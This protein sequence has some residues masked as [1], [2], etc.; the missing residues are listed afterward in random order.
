M[1]VI[2]Q[3]TGLVVMI[4]AVLIMGIGGYGVTSSR[5]LFRQLLSIE[6]IF[7]GLLLLILS[8]ISFNAIM[9]TYFGI[10]IISVV[11]AEVIVVVS[12]LVAYMRESKSLSS[13]DLEEGGV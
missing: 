3:L 11:S 10:I 6:V 2:D 1:I 5:S 13:E 12:I 8:L 7:N 9:A 4:T